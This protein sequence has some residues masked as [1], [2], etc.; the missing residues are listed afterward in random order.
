MFVVLHNPPKG[1]ARLIGPF[2]SAEAAGEWIHARPKVS[3]KN[4]VWAAVEKP[5]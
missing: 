2:V 4:Y 1:K 3:W 5:G